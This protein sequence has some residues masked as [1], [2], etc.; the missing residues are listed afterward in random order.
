MSIRTELEADATPTGPLCPICREVCIPAQIYVQ[1]EAR[2]NS[3][4]LCLNTAAHG[5]QPNTAAI[6][7]AWEFLGEP[8]TEAEAR[9][10]ERIIPW[11]GQ[12]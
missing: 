9:A 11:E 3:E 6:W 10:L 4:W 7:Y 1:H 2:N 5:G 12:P 8:Y